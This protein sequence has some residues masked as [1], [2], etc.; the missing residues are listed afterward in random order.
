MIEYYVNDIYPTIQGEGVQAGMPMVMLRLHGCGVGCPW[1]DTKETWDFNPDLRV[2]GLDEIQGKDGKHAL[3]DGADITSYIAN[4]FPSFKWVL[5]SGGEPADYPLASLVQHLHKAGYKVSLETS[6][7]ADGF[8]GAGIDW[9]TVSP[10]F[11]MPGGK[12]VLPET[13]RHADEIKH[14]VGKPADVLKIE[15]VL[16]R[17]H[18][19][20][21]IICLQPVSQSKKATEICLDACMTRGWRLSLQMHKYIDVP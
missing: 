18:I 11:D 2:S 3:A 1:C 10:K 17:N 8:I 19:E 6:G 20:G 13:F 7:T 16:K 9:V 12:E 21:V 15:S 14:V 4:N 5:L